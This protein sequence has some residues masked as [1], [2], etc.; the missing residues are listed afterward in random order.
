[1]QFQ[2]DFG[3][4]TEAEAATLSTEEH[5]THRYKAPGLYEVTLNAMD[6]SSQASASSKLV[7]VQR[8]E[9]TPVAGFTFKVSLASIHG[10]LAGN[11]NAC[12]LNACGGVEPSP[13]PL[14]KSVSERTRERE[15][16]SESERERE[17]AR[18]KDRRANTLTRTPTT[19]SCT[20][21]AHTPSHTRAHASRPRHPPT[22]ALPDKDTPVHIAVTSR[23]FDVVR[24]NHPM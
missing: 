11:D 2:W 23:V 18:E 9:H 13:L 12:Y 22:P 17:R 24:V 14:P 21:D 7:R 8:L 5:P 16:E 4:G 19:H 3:D 1:M 20:Y 15:Q 6:P 10:S